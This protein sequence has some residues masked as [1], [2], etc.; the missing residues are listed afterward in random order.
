MEKEEDE[1][2]A[3]MP[4]RT[5]LIGGDRAGQD[6]DRQTSPSGGRSIRCALQVMP[7][8][9]YVVPHAHHLTAWRRWAASGKALNTRYALTGRTKVSPLARGWG[10]GLSRRPGLHWCGG[11]GAWCT[12]RT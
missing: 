1:E 7:D 2:D 12:P 4:A 5:R 8:F 11:G 3:C 6:K 10:L 9:G